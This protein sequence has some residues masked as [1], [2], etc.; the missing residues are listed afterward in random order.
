MNNFQTFLALDSSQAGHLV[1]RFITP[2][3]VYEAP[4]YDI[5]FESQLIPEIDKLLQKAKTTIS[6][7]DA[8]VL[9]KGP[10]SFMGLRLGFSVFRTWAWV[11]N[12]PIIT[13]SSLELLKRSFITTFEEFQNHLIIPCIDAKMKKVFANISDQQ[14]EYLKDCDISPIDLSIHIK[15]LPHQKIIIIGSGANLIK[16]QLSDMNNIFF[17]DGYSLQNNCF[18]KEFLQSIDQIHFSQKS[19][20]L[21]ETIVP[22]YLRVSAAEEALL[23]KQKKD[24]F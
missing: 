8:F 3:D 23:E 7:I 21:L 13:I 20:D 11:F 2:N 18:S 15:K 10:G 6:E 14:N 22:Q 4:Q 1:L 16:E 24:P 12:K 9:G 17:Y 5:R 19:K